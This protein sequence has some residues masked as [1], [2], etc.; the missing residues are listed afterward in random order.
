MKLS[1]GQYPITVED[2]CESV[3]VESPV[4]D[5]SVFLQYGYVV[6]FEQPRPEVDKLYKVYE[7]TPQKDAQG[8]YLQTF[9]IVDT[10]ANAPKHLLNRVLEVAISEKLSD[11][12]TVRWQRETLG[13]TLAN[14]VQVKTDATSQSKIHAAL[15]GLQNGYQSSIMFKTASGPIELNLEALT[16]V[17]KAVYNYVQ[18]CF[19]AEAT[20][21]AEIKLLTNPHDVYGYDVNSGW[22]SNINR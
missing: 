6:V 14:G 19:A 21:I 7:I 17:S 3:G 5:P 15:T 2:F 20:K 18:E 12:A 8:R 16:A 10:I 4:T 22:P 13:I 9:K 1:T 11:L